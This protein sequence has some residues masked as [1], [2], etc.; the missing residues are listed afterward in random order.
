M[1]SLEDLIAAQRAQAAVQQEKVGQQKAEGEALLTT[2]QAEINPLYDKLIGETQDAYKTGLETARTSASQAGI[3]RSGIR[4]NKEL[5]LGQAAAKQTGEYGAERTRKLSD[6]ARR[7]TLLANQAALNAKE[8]DVNLGANIADIR[9]KDYQMQEAARLEREK[10]AQQERIAAANRAATTETPL[11][12]AQ[13]TAQL[14]SGIEPGDQSK[15]GTIANLIETQYG[16]INPGDAEDKMIR[17]HMYPG[18]ETQYAAPAPSFS[19]KITP[20]ITNNS[21]YKQMLA[22]LF[23]K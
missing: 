2:E 3:Y 8:V 7:R 18:G 9:Y 6:I 14:L 20:Y 15:W 12:K 4:Y 13:Y 1:A 17:Q 22:P 19:S 11:N 5:A 16:K 23:R 21:F 10:M